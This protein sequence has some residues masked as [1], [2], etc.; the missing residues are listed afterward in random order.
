[1]S[2]HNYRTRASI[3]RSLKFA[4]FLTCCGLSSTLF[5]AELPKVDQ[6]MDMEASGEQVN[7]RMS[8]SKEADAVSQW[9]SGRILIDGQWLELEQ[10][11]EHKLAPH[12]AEYFKLRDA[13]TLDIEGNRRMAFWCQ[14]HQLPEMANVHWKAV[15]AVSLDDAQARKALGHKR[16][17]NNWFT[18]EELDRASKDYQREKSSLKDWMPKVRKLV[19][20]LQSSDTKLKIEG[21]KDLEGVHGEDAIPALKYGVVQLEPTIALLLVNKIKSIRC[22][23]SCLALCDIALSD[24]NSEVGRSAIEGLRQYDERLYVPDLLQTLQ[25]PISLSQQIFYMPNGT[26]FVHR[27]YLRES[28]TEKEQAEVLKAAMLFTPSVTLDMS[29]VI[30]NTNN[31]NLN[32]FFPAE[33]KVNAIN[34]QARSSIERLSSINNE[35]EARKAD[36][37]N[38]IQQK[39][40]ANSKLIL[41]QLSGLAPTE[42]AEVFWGWWPDFNDEATGDKRS[43]TSYAIDDTPYVSIPN[44]LTV[45]TPH[46]S[47]L[48][49]GTIVQSA[50]GPKSI[51]SFKIGDSVAS[52][53]IETGEISLRPVT[54]VSERTASA[55]HVIHLK[56][57]EAIRATGGHNWWVVGK[58]WTRSRDLEAGQLI[59]TGDSSVEIAKLEKIEQPIKVYNLIVDQTHTYFVGKDRLLSWDVTSLQ[60]TLQKVPGK[61]ESGQKLATR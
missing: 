40:E 4:A 37:W 26:L 47:C 1:M 21:M 51:E 18:P 54:H 52:I 19:L 38:K 14:A 24:A 22:K 42:K 41:S 53:N 25:V 57:N 29:K 31:P 12:I 11:K 61:L 49:A 58:G 23:A 33:I 56:N 2:P 28:M 27:A 35:V 10:L 9:Q 59:R 20:K 3:C 45:I 8:L 50:N 32:C 30:A 44:Q 5:S 13:K 48:V 39:R 17:G 7:R 15:V 46:S 16:I 43:F 36:I 60:P 55:T 6:V 34:D